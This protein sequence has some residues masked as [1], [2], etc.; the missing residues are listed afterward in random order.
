MAKTGGYPELPK[1]WKKY[2]RGTDNAIFP[3]IMIDDKIT[4]YGVPQAELK[5]DAGKGISYKTVSHVKCRI[6]GKYTAEMI[7]SLSDLEYV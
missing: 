7:K 1:H 6:N 3:L 2:T 5:L 4:W